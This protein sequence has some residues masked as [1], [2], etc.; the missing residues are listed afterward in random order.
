[1]KYKE[2]FVFYISIKNL[3]FNYVNKTL[4]Y[5]NL[6]VILNRN[7]ALCQLLYP[8]SLKKSNSK[9]VLVES[10]TFNENRRKILDYLIENIII[11]NYHLGIRDATTIRRIK[12]IKYFINYSDKNK[13]DFLSDIKYAQKTF[14][15]YTK[16]LQTCIKNSSYTQR[17][18]SILQKEALKMLS[19]V[20]N[21]K[22][23][24]IRENTPIIHSGNETRTTQAMKEDD[25]NYCFNFYY[26]LFNNIYNF[27]FQKEMY[28]FSMN[29]CN[30]THWLMPYSKS[31]ISNIFKGLKTSAFDPETGRVSSLEDLKAKSSLD[32]PDINKDSH[33][34]AIHTFS[35]HLKMANS[36]FDSEE[37]KQ[38]AIL[39]CKAY[40]IIFLF[41][42]G[43]NDV[44]A[45]TLL[46]DEEFSIEKNTHDFRNIKFR[47]NNKEVE[48]QIAS[49]FIPLFKKYLKMREYLLQSNNNNYLFFDG[50]GDST[51]MS[52]TRN[53][54]C[55]SSSINNRFIIAFKNNKLR[56]LT[57]RTIRLYKTKYLIKNHGVITSSNIVQTNISTL[58]KH[59]TGENEEFA[60][61]QITTFFE[62]LNKNALNNKDDSLSIPAGHCSDYENP[63]TS[64]ALKEI[65]SDC[66]KSE[67]CLFCE[68]FRCHANEDDIRKLFSILFIIEE[69]RTKASSPSHFDSIYLV[70]IK[71]IN[72]L[73]FEIA[74]T[75]KH[76]EEIRIDVFKNENLSFYWEKRLEMLIE[77]GVL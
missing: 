54:G 65:K 13:L 56:N 57:S 33:K 69:S 58:L 10:L 18:A 73:I 25:I 64:F 63:K 1:M 3:E 48:F 55:L 35:N 9:Y 27:I 71:R 41:T 44:V 11:R 14:L 40:Y 61:E 29:I 75:N 34:R 66:K 50:H 15:R 21:I 2:V 38:V 47:A 76:T 16:Y 4:D 28:P 43:M 70:V 52:T 42:T 49:K 12:E 68:H 19:I 59:Y 53:S 46:W 23:I 5:S 60:G 67:G 22:E 8:K 20:H 36:S 37:R 72:N 24:E 45:S 51:Y 30:E 74:K 6:G 39:G 17:T 26:Q 31:F 7:Y 62:S 77:I 32:L